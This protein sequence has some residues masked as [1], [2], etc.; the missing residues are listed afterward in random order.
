MSKQKIIF[1]QITSFIPW[2]QF[3]KI[4]DDFN[5]DYRFKSFKSRDHLLVMIFAQITF[6]ESLR[7]IESSLNSQ[8]SKLYHMGIRCEK[9]ARN[10]IANADETRDY[11]IYEQLAN[12]LTA[13]AKVLYQNE[14]VLDDLEFDKSIYALDS[15]VINIC[16]SL[17][18]W[19]KYMEKRGIGA[20]KLHSMIDLKGNLPSFNVITDGKVY[21][22]E[23]LDI[24]PFEAGSIYVMDRGYLD[25]KR[26]YNIEQNK[27][28]FITR[29][30]SNI[31][32]KRISSNKNIRNKITRNANVETNVDE[33]IICDQ[34][35]LFVTREAKKS[36]PQKLRRIKYRFRDKTNGKASTKF[37][38]LTFVTNNFTLEAITIARLYKKRWQIE[39]FF[40]WIKQHLKIKT[41]YSN[42]ENG[43]KI[44]IWTAICTYLLVAIMKKEL[45]IKHSLYTIL[46][47]LSV[48]IFERMPVNQLLGDF[49]YNNIEEDD[50][51]LLLL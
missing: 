16:L 9:I 48:N 42:C 45:K 24:L 44:Q 7:A 4:V 41:F 21:D 5:G 6:R 36:Y 14:K 43:V 47:I 32:F 50:R 30:T 18:P 49:D 39:L 40:K 37:K 33:V 2:Y 11:R 25:Y 38:S 13:R 1:S 3:D 19:A 22:G 31:K 35:V 27:A 10:T 17:S 8:R 26:L 28:F 29:A 20:I 12:V 51:Q 23:I 15:S 34:I 46:Q